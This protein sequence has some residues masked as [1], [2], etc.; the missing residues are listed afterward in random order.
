MYIENKETIELILK[1]YKEFLIK[2]ESSIYNDI[3]IKFDN[4]LRNNGINIHNFFEIS[5]FLKNII[6]LLTLKIWNSEL[7]DN[8]IKNDTFS[9]NNWICVKLEL[10]N[11]IDVSYLEFNRNEIEMVILSII[12]RL[13]VLETLRKTS[14]SNYNSSYLKLELDSEIEDYLR[15][16]YFRNSEFIETIDNIG[17]YKNYLKNIRNQITHHTR[18]IYLPKEARGNIIN[19]V[20]NYT[21]EFMSCILYY[22]TVVKNYM[23]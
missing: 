21:Y 14:N 6:N 4:F 20:K 12:N 18:L 10:I 9:F 3:L 2:N 8:D 19:I 7:L 16:I 13:D 17:F 23:I 11:N 1:N 22:V 15:K 5:L